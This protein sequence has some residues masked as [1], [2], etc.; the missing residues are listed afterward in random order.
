MVSHWPYICFAQMRRH[1]LCGICEWIDF[2]RDLGGPDARRE[3][4]DMTATIAN[5]GPDDEGTWI[6]G[7]AALGHHRLAIID[8]QGGRQPRMLQGDGRPDLVLVYTGETYNY[9]ELRQQLA[10]LVHRMNTSSDTEVVLHRPR[11]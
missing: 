1:N 11:E 10:G 5:H 2:N 9:R 6:G 7:P 4:A 8:I 3:L